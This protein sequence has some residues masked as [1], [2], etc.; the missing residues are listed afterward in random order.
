MQS[1]EQFQ[2]QLAGQNALLVAD[3]EGREMTSFDALTPRLGLGWRCPTLGGLISRNG[4]LLE[5]S[6][7]NTAYGLSD[8]HTNK[9]HNQ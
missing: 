8:K 3:G 4:R 5:D 6:F 7:L 1:G 2:Q 9:G